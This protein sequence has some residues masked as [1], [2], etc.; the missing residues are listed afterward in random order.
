MQYLRQIKPFC[1]LQNGMEVVRH[2]AP[3]EEQVSFSI[4]VPQF[5]H[6]HRGN[7]GTAKP[8]FTTARV[9]IRVDARRV[10]LFQAERVIGSHLAAF[11]G[12]GFQ[13]FSFGFDLF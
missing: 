8:A 7:F 11:C 3:G 13:G 12:L 4:E 1:R 6:N 10:E 9:E 5:I 2:H